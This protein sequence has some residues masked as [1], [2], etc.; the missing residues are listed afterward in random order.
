MVDGV[1]LAKYG[2]RGSDESV[3]NI[4][5]V[6]DEF[7]GIKGLLL[8]NHGVFTFAA[9]T[10]EDAFRGRWMTMDVGDVDRDG[11]PDVLL[12][13]NV[14]FAPLGDTTGLFARWRREAP[15]FLLLEN[16]R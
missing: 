5:T 7:E 4:A 15:S 14:G 13:S 3:N 2:P 8:E 16:T 6:I 10:F 1:P 9:R 12:G 11:D